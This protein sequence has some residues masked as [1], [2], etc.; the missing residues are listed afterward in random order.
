M[1]VN[2]GPEAMAGSVRIR[3]R[4]KG[5]NPPKLT[6]TSVLAARET[7]TTSPRY[8]DITSSMLDIY[9][10]MLSNRMNEVMKVLT[11]IATIF[12]SSTFIAGIYGMNFEIMPELKWPLGYPM[13]WAVV[14]LIGGAMV[15]YFKRKKW[16]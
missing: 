5:T 2:N 6:A 9:L 13:V 11:L 8:G 14:V 15:L 4:S 7:P 3:R 16:L 1:V 12:I 10:S